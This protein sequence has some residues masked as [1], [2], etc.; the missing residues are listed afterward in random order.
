MRNQFT[1]QAVQAMKYAGSMA[2]KLKNPYIGTEHLLLGLRH[3]YT[4]MAGQILAQYGVE[5]EKVLKI[6]GELVAPGE[7]DVFQGNPIES[8]R[9]KYLYENSEREALYFRTEKIG[10]EHMLLAMIHDVDCVATRMLIT[11]NV[12]LQKMM[13][14]ILNGLGEDLKEYQEEM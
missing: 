12:N 11:L 10:T 1:Q 5:E 14:D 4:G 6:M 7:T 3:E 2:K 8:P 13:G 9:L